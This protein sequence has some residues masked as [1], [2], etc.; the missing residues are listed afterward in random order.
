MPNAPVIPGLRFDDL[1]FVNDSTGW[2]VNGNGEIYKTSDF[3]ESWTMQFYDGPQYFRS[4]EFFD[5]QNGLVGSLDGAVYRTTDGGATWNDIN[6]GLTEPVPGV[7][8]IGHYGDTVLLVGIWSQPA[9]IVRSIDAGATWSYIDMSALAGGLV[10]CWFKGP[11]TVFV[12]G[13][14]TNATNGHGVILRSADAG[15]TWQEV[16]QSQYSNTYGWKLQFT[17]P[18][19]GYASLA[20]ATTPD[21][22]IMKTVDGGASWTTMTVVNQNIDMEGI[23]FVND[24]EGWVGG[25]ST[26]MYH[27]TDGGNSW[28]YLNMGQNLN[29]YFFLSPELGYASGMSIYKF[30]DVI[31]DV[32]PAPAVHDVSTHQC[33][34]YPNPSTGYVSI[35]LQIIKPTRTILTVYDQNGRSVK[36]IFNGRL[37]AGTHDY[38]VDLSNMAPGIYFS[39]L[40]TDE[41]FLTKRINLIESDTPDVR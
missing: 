21:S 35:N 13:K 16:G 27:T 2:A 31:T 30:T 12:C 15:L 34:V 33:D 1:Y 20:A 32:T 14:G 17:S 5:D 36:E 38:A 8:G 29:R 26:G 41:H 23:G 24:L 22:H 37:P 7:C 11:D 25:W 40:R 3:G 6:L 39:V 28:T 4:V 19:I 18:L 10:D 9:F